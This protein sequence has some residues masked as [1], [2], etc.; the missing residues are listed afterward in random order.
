MPLQNLYKRCMDTSRSVCCLRLMQASKK[1]EDKARTVCCHCRPEGEHKCRLFLLSES[2]LELTNL[3][4]ME[5]S[6]A[7]CSTSHIYCWL[8]FRLSGTKIRAYMYQKHILAEGC[9]C[10][11]ITPVSP[12][13]SCPDSSE[14]DT[15]LN[16]S[17]NKLKTC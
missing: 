16:Y 17:Y 5:I 2:V 4:R 7:H 14:D 9:F 13:A 3:L 11:I 6:P 15:R 8:L 1:L 12:A 10:L